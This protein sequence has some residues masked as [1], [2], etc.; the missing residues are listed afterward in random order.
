MKK[1]RSIDKYSLKK[2]VEAPRSKIPASGNKRILPGT[3]GKDH[4]TRPEFNGN[5]RIMGAVFRAG[6][7]SDF[8]GD[9]GLF[10]HRKSPEYCS[11]DPVISGAFLP[12]TVIFPDGSRQDPLVSGGRN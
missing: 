4:R 6:M 12:D 8:S 2:R 3:V 9:F 7:S 5:H 11:H 1:L 10:S